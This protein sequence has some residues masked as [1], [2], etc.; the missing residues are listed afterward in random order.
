MMIS[1]RVLIAVKPEHRQRFIA[2]STTMIE[3]TRAEPGCLSF[4]FYQDAADPNTFLFYEEF[5]DR[6]AV[7]LH[8]QTAYRDQWWDDV[9]PL[10]AAP[11]EA[12]ILTN[13]EVVTR[14]LSKEPH[15]AKRAKV[16]FSV[17]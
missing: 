11:V 13:C 6:A 8:D 7:L 17:G 14:N 10:L 15:P 16:S 3:Q 12:R 9:E 2:V 5:A 1:A 4:G